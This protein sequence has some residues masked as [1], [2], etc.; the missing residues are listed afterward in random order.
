[1]ELKTIDDWVVE[2][3]F[4]SVPGV[5]DDSGLGGETMQ[6][7]VVLDPAK[8]AGAGL[9]VPAIANSLGANN[10]NAGGGFY[11][12]GGQFYYVRGLGRL[13]TPED[14]GNVVLSMH[15]G[16]PV[17]V[18]DIGK[19]VIGA[20]PR[21]GQ[22]GYMDQ[23]DAVEGVILMRTG[24]KTQSVLQAVEAKTKEL[25]D[26]DPAQGCQN[27]PL[28]RPERVDCPDNQDGG[29]QP[30]AWH[31][32]G[33]HRPHLF[34]L[35]SSRRLDRGHRHPAGHVVRLYLSGS[36]KCLRQSAFHRRGGLRHS[37]GWRGGH[38]REI[39]RQV[40]ARRGSRST[41]GK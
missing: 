9:S 13:V 26:Q 36:E 5:A 25:N 27:P 33:R 1:M 31:G 41:S 23:D 14:I 3:Q 15:N 37:G 29:G 10:G 39:F 4:K 35:R 16:T 22:F 18:K 6:Y 20:A 8:V 32:A 11:S 17:L 30:A 12:Q 34:P 21:L 7:Q 38:G 24:E 19:V 28:L 2:R 40:A